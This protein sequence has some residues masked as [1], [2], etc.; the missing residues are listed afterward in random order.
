VDA[1]K[2]LDAD[3]SMIRNYQQ[4]MD[5]VWQ[6]RPI[7]KLF[8]AASEQRRARKIL[9]MFLLAEQNRTARTRTLY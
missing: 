4:M 9:N 6:V 3:E 1:F 2:A 7:S 5:G 8:A